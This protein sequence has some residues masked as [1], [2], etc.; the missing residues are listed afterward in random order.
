MNIQNISCGLA[1][2]ATLALA[3]PALAA[4]VP[5]NHWLADSAYPVSHHNAGQTD[6]TPV[7]GPD[8]GKRLSVDEVQSVPHPGL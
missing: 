7:D 5:V 3:L 2:T 8:V 4:G 6:S 1:A